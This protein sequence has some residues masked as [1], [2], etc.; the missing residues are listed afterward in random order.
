MLT[1][2]LALPFDP[3]D[4]IYRTISQHF[5]ENPDEFADVFVR[6]LFKLTHRDI[7]PIARYLGPEAPKEEFIWQDLIPTVT[8]D[9]IDHQDATALKRKILASGLFVSEL[10]ATSWASASTF[11]GS[12]KCGSVNGRRICPLKKFLRGLSVLLVK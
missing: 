7:G 12:D 10:V 6:A 8:H 3:F 11:R 4:P 2:N 9:L 1:T 5:Y